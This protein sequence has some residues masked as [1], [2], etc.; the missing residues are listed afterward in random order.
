LVC[1][2][3]DAPGRDAFG[4]PP[5]GWIVRDYPQNV[6]QAADREL[7]EVVIPEHARGLEL[8]QLPA[9]RLVQTRTAGVDWIIELIPDGVTLC[10]ATGSRDAA[11]AEWVVAA[12]L[13]DYKRART[14]AEQQSARR[15]EHIDDLLDVAGS[16]VLILGY[17]AIGRAVEERLKPFGTSFLRV[18]RSPREGVHSVAELAELLPAADVIV[19]LLPLTDETRGLVGPEFLGLMHDGVVFVNAGR[20]KTVD[21]DG[22]VAELEAG[23]IRAVVD[24]VDPEP[25]PADHPLWTLPGAIISPHCAGDTIGAERAAWRLAGEQLHRYAA[26]EP[27]LNVVSDGY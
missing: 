10:D 2:V 5:D 12:I 22:L 11:M 14:Y 15:W 25:L 17:G 8:E 13:A 9:L 1:W 24:V 19:N 26:D 7:V 27:L 20:G 18:A 3:H 4:P 21:T 23:R 6:A 16:R